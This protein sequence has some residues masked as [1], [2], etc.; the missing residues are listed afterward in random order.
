MLAEYPR[1]LALVDS[2]RRAPVRRRTP[3][4]RGHP[5]D[6]R[7]APERECPRLAPA[8]A[9][10][11]SDAS[12]TATVPS[13]NPSAMLLPSREN[14]DCHRAPWPAAH[15]SSSLVRRGVP[16]QRVPLGAAGHDAAPVRAELRGP[17]V[18]ASRL[19]GRHVDGRPRSPRA[20]PPRPRASRAVSTAQ[21]A[22][23][24]ASAGS[25]SMLFSR[26]RRERA[27]GRA[28]SLALGL[29][30]LLDRDGSDHR[31]RDE[32]E[33]EA[34]EGERE[35][36][37]AVRA[38]AAVALEAGLEEVV[39][40]GPAGR[41]RTSRTSRAPRRAG[42]RGTARRRPRRR[43]AI[44]AAPALRLRSILRSSRPSSIHPCS[45]GHSRSS[46]SCASSTVPSLTVTSRRSASTSS[47]G[48]ASAPRSVSGIRRRST[49][50]LVVDLDELE[51]HAAR[52]LALLVVEVRE[53]LL[54]QPRDRA[55]DSARPLVGGEAQAP[56]VAVLPELEQ[57]RRERAAA[58]PA[59]PRR[60]RRSPRTSSS[61]TD[62]PTRCA[63]QAIARRSSSGCIG[64]DE[65]VVG[66]QQARRAPG[67]RRSGRRS[68]RAARSRRRRPA[69]GRAREMKA[70]RSASS[71]QTVNVSSN[72]STAST[73]R[74]GASGGRLLELAQRVLAGPDHALRPALAAREHAALRGR[75]GGR[76][77]RPTT[78]RC[79]TGRRRRAAARRRAARPARRRAARGRRS[80]ARRRP[81]TR[82]GP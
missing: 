12:V 52:E 78:C 6:E 13:S 33:R 61:S 75:A 43:G 4:R 59:R 37:A 41:G 64:P 44:R 18:H 15:R 66:G 73:K 14:R 35:P 79:P 55:A 29:A 38:V 31:D 54:G 50:A 53:R 48:S 28:V 1:R 25:T 23:L 36:P 27:G 11:P 45:R 46:A 72:W 16:E 69:G 80:T 42:L 39:A 65:D 77:A 62:R 7:D 82:R 70:A 19:A 67:T 58:R 20:A 57:R 30:S 76:P 68:R 21:S 9:R 74:S 10:E 5:P 24:R 56:P 8:V 32:A 63:G 81:R 47:R 34:S 51:E 17:G 2:E 26:L 3:R 49:A 40:R 22:S 71:R 60:R